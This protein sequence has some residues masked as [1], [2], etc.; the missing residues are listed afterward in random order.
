MQKQETKKERPPKPKYNMWQNS[1]FMVKLAWKEKEKKVLFFCLSIALL[2]VANNLLGLY[3]TPTILNAV[4][5][6]A[7]LQTL[8]HTILFFV[9]ASLLI[10]ACSGYVNSNEEYGKITLRSCLIAM[11]NTKMACTSYPNTKDTTLLKMVGDTDDA[12]NSNRAPGEAIWNTLTELLQ[13][14]ICFLFYVTLLSN[15]DPLLAVVTVITCLAGYA[16]HKPLS[17]FTYRHRDEFLKN[18]RVLD[19]VN[20]YAENTKM[21][22][23]IRIFGIADYLREIFHKT[24]AALDALGKRAENA[25]LIAR[26]SDLSLEF[27]RNSVAYAYLIHMVLSGDLSASAFLLYF[28]AV[29]NFSAWISGILGNLITLNRHSA[30]ISTI[31]ECLEYPEPFRF[32]DGEP[33]TADPNGQYT[34]RL[35]HVSYRYPKAEKDTL[36][37][38]SLTLHSGEK[39]AIVGLNGAGK[40]TL[41]KLLCGF[42]DPTEGTVFLND[43]DIRT[44]NR[45]E[46]YTL[47][48]AVFQDFTL[49]PATVA[50]NVAQNEDDIDL[51][52]VKSCIEKA[53]LQEKIESLP[54]QYE[55]HLNRD[56]YSDAVMLS[57]GETQRLMLARALYK[58]APLIILDE[59]TAALDPIAEADLYNKYHEMTANRSSVYISHRLASTRFCDRIILIENGGIAE[60]GTHQ[61]LLD[62]KGR[63]AELFEIQSKYYREGELSDEME[64][65]K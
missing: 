56:I 21:A 34:I 16:I 19:T 54:G 12:L 33:L 42:L 47:F 49:L 64:T 14:C 22:K 11:L 36:T 38:L 63:Y 5:T 1:A 10:N 32:E 9:G 29:G 26:I 20:H 61:E 15:L 18:S 30:K 57:G 55:N 62:R 43:V 45:R 27:L 50:A 23:D 35:E 28:S 44:F 24:S 39:L 65:E 46:Y 59:P 25:T 51:D 40:T 31:R 13:N 41:V 48:S 58:N 7:P 6:G 37:D 8:L 4:E 52:L 60:E 17:E 3:I 2:G 53:G